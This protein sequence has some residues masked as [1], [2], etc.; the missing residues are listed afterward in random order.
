[1]ENPSKQNNLETKYDVIIVGAGIGGLTCASWLA[2]KSKKVLVLEKNGFIGGRC[3]SY[4][5]QGFT[6]DFGIHGFSL[7]EKGPLQDV[8]RAA[9]SKI[10]INPPLLS[11][12]KFRTYLKYKESILYPALPVNFTHFWNLFRI[13]GNV[14]RMKATKWKDKM[15]IIKTAS[16][17]LFLRMK[18]QE[19]LEHITVKEMLE[20]LSDSQVAQSII[21]SSADCV[22]V[23]PYHQYVARDYLDNLMGLLKSGGIWYP[24]GGCGAVP[25]AFSQIIER[26]GGTIMTGQC[27]EEIL[28]NESKTEL[29]QPQVLG[30]KLQGC[31]KE[32][33][34]PIVVV[35]VHFK[36]LLNRLLKKPYFPESVVNKVRDLET[37]LSAIV[38][39]IAL[40][41]QVFPQK[42]IMESPML[43]EKKN[44]N[45][46]HEEPIGG[47]FVFPS[48]IDRD[49]APPGKQ[50]VIAGLGVDPSR[51]DEKDYLTNYLIEKLQHLAP[52][53]I[54]IRD[55][56]EWMD[57]TSQK[58]LDALFGEGGAVVGIASNVK[59][60]R[61]CRLE[62]RTP[63]KGLYHCGDDSGIN[64]WGVGTELAA[65]SGRQCAELILEQKT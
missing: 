22:S 14:F 62:S 35:N 61:G 18:D 21:A 48:N 6:I 55:H 15:A 59:Q 13:I 51:M 16:G 46:A 37:S 52:Q 33:Y 60:A 41:A 19:P 9:K 40:D 28:V 26:C 30:V 4:K 17:L 42:I 3:A 56:I 25:N 58:E 34:A 45:D 2:L 38:V 64:L 57:V 47:L 24:K 7:G 20:R 8:M 49:L 10:R 44:E 12:F 29:N 31:Q 11:W 43:I 27:V 65:K 1:M 53:G 50:L 5:K 63:V 39:H 23:I 32:I 36:E 54:K